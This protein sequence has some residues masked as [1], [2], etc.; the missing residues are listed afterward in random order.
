MCVRVHG[1]PDIGVTEDFLQ[2]FDLCAGINLT[3]V[4]ICRKPIDIL[5]CMDGAV[6]HGTEPGR[7][8]AREVLVQ[9]WPFSRAIDSVL[10]LSAALVCFLLALVNA[11]PINAVAPL[12]FIVKR[13][14]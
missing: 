10:D 9:F 11:F 4:N 14:S 3:V 7:F 8:P 1:D 5:V 13:Y 2:R 12:P 6:A